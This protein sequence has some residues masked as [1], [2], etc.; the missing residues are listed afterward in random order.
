MH[1]YIFTHTHAQCHTHRVTHTDVWG[2]WRGSWPGRRCREAPSGS[3]SAVTGLDIA[4][5]YNI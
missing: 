3:P 4:A 2:L 5:T 1:T